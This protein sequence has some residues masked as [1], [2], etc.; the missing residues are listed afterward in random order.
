MD[1]AFDVEAFVARVGRR[2]VEQFA[3]A[4]AATSPA[5][6][7]AAMEQPVKEQ[8]EQILPRGIK[9]GSGFVIDSVGGTSRQSDLVLY[10]R[11]ICPMFSINNTPETT[12]YPCE[13]VIAICEVKSTLDRNS[14]EDAFQKIASVKK[15][16][17]FQVFHPVPISTGMRPILTRGYGTIQCDPVL[18]ATEGE[19]IPETAQIFGC[20]IAGD[21]RIR[22]D[23]LCASFKELSQETGD[24]LSPNMVVILSGGL[25]TWGNFT[26]AKVRET[27]WSNPKQSYIL[28]ETPGDNPTVEPMWSRRKANCFSY[29]PEPE[30]FRSLIHWLSGIYHEGKTSDAKAFEQYIMRKKT[31]IQPGLNI[32]PKGNGTIEELLEGLS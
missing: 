17:R 15:L 7:G 29:S 28:S 16:K 32:Y 9:I 13:G 22:P 31:S 21:L 4:R 24:E 20:V 18:T 23:T 3:D 26:R 1:L 25:I 5:T 12:Y 10:E 11:D 19:E 30:P 14:L 8:M 6:V 27:I 2:L